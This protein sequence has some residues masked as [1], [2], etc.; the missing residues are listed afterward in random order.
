M[1]RLETISFL[2]QHWVAIPG[3]P[4]GRLWS[5]FRLTCTT[6]RYEDG[7]DPEISLNFQSTTRSGWRYHNA[8][9]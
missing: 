5:S 4:M 2:P 7:L 9:T 1:K 6:G 8:P 3:T